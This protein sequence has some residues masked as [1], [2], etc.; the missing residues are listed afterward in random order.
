MRIGSD[1][2]YYLI[3]VSWFYEAEQPT[4][5]CSGQRFAYRCSIVDGAVTNKGNGAYD[6]TLTVTWNGETITNGV[7][8]QSNKNGDHEYRFYLEFGYTDNSVK[9]NQYY[10]VTG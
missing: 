3:N 2:N 8:S 4:K 10:R 7:L 6:Y 9:R 5:L 1:T